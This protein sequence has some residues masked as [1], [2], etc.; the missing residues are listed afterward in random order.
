MDKQLLL[1]CLILVIL[2]LVLLA[3][4]LVISSPIIGVAASLVFLSIASWV[5]GVL[6]FSKENR[7][8]RMTFGFV[9]VIMFLVL[10][11]NVL[12]VIAGFKETVSLTAVAALGVILGWFFVRFR[13]S[14]S[15]KDSSESGVNQNKKMTKEAVL[16]VVP[17]LV[18]TTVAFWMLWLGRTDEG[19]ASVWLTIPNSFIPLFLFVSFSLLVVLVFTRLSNSLKLGLVCLYSFLVHSLFLLVWYPGRYGDPWVHLGEARYIAKTGMP[20]AYDWMIQQRLIAQLVVRAQHAL[21]V[22]FGRMFFV[23]VYWVNIMLV[24][25]LW[26]ILVPLLAYII[27]EMMTV[28]KSRMFPILSAV[29]TLLFP[30][31]ISWGTVS[32]ANSLG[33]VF[34]FVSVAL[35]IAWMNHGDYRMWLLSALASISSFLSHPQPGLFAFLLLSW[36]TV[37]HKTTRRIWSVI[38]YVLLFLAYPLS[39]LYR[40]ASFSLGGLLVLDN[41]LSFQSEMSTILLVF[42]VV[43]LILSVKNHFVN[44]RSALV[45]FIT[46][47]TLLSEFY[48]TVFGM[49][50]LPFDAQ[51]ILTMADFLLVPF[52]ALGFIMIARIYGKV[53][54]K[55]TGN[56]SISL[57]HKGFKVIL[58]RVSVGFLIIC[59]FLSLQ[60]TLALYQAYPHDEIVK[61]QPSAYELETIEYINSD[62][63]GAYVVLCDTTFADLAVG[64]LGIDYGYPSNRGYFGIPEWWYPTIKMYVEMTETPSIG[65]MK[66]ALK[67]ASAQSSYFVVSIRNPDFEEVVKR[68]LEIL[69]AYRTFGDDQL[70]LFRYPTPVVEEPGSPVK[71][72]FD[73]G[74]GGEQDVQTRF[75]Y[76]V[77]TEVNSTLT[78]A[79]HTS[80]NVTYF[81][82]HWTF[83]E[84]TVNNVSRGFDES[85]DINKFVY[86]N[87][88][89]LS[90]VL[91][92]K[93]LFNSRYPNVGWKEDS[94]KTLD[95][96]HSHELYIGTMVPDI[97]SDGNILRLSYSFSSGS[98]LYYYYV[99]SVSISTNDYPYLSMRWRSNE[100]VAVAAVY[101]VGGGSQI[102]VPFGGIS[103]EW[104]TNVVS[105]PSDVTITMVVVGLSN[106]RDQQVTGTGTMEVDY[107]LFAAKA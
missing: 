79:G 93:W 48:L 50:N 95:N 87:G 98:Y 22:F 51:R 74:L 52:V 106:A 28:K 1:T 103:P 2:P 71:I 4:A 53:A 34:F 105:L 36:V 86:V 91:T 14:H 3:N 16:F 96:W 38:I 84:L 25:L 55:S 107:I 7:V 80:Y 102:I 97:T 24:P 11:G 100:P 83:L 104:S 59:L 46:Y 41:F 17:F 81:P 64:F 10:T 92:I 23:D 19:G 63:R 57:P 44:T 15:S 61:V 42:G 5:T 65:I 40:Q 69:P 76:M 33:F 39:L 72:V 6:L 88:L 37:I 32:V 99:T 56:P 30:S 12:I 27:A 45:L 58:S 66:Q 60:A 94:F 13:N 43:G 82:A 68:T 77:D 75:A 101:F 20:Y 73:D 67:F 8:F 70:Y 90:D 62:T 9:T 26:S 47:V 31:L 54:S 18:T 78:L 29:A 21:T 89:Q 85:S 35:L 49:T